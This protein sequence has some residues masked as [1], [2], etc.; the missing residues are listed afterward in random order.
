MFIG[1]AGLEPLIYGIII[2]FGVLIVI[3]K[4]RWGMYF[5]AVVDVA[6]FV[7]VFS[8]HGGTL[9][10]GMGAAVAALICGFVV[11]IFFRRF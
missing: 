6:V 1:H 4:L 5:G 11:P 9:K 2:A 10:G 8:M 7:L 3:A